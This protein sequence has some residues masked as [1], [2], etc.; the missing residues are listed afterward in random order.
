M[1]SGHLVEV[2]LVE[3]LAHH[4]LLLTVLSSDGYLLHVVV[5]LNLKDALFFFSS[6]IL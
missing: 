4:H 6:I 1:T 2:V 3:F 5:E